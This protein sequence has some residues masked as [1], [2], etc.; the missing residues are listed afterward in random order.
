M[1]H[2]QK[3]S[4]WQRLAPPA[5]T[6]APIHGS[7]STLFDLPRQKR[8]SNHTAG[9]PNIAGISRLLKYKG[10]NSARKF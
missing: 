10:V 1:A 4:Q 8:P 6:D 2:Q 3:P 5:E 9:E 7:P